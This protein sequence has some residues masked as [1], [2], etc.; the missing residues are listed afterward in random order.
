M[1]RPKVIELGEGE[2]RARIPIL[3]EDRS[4][5]AIDKPAGWMLVPF[6]WQRTQRNLPAALTSS[7][8]AGDFWATS[9]NLK[10]L[11]NVHR[12]DTDTTGVLL[13]VKSLGAVRPLSDLFRSRAMEK[14]YLAVVRGRPRK[15]EWICRDRLAKDPDQIGRM[16]VD[17][18]A[19][20]EAETRFRV[21]RAGEGS[22]VVEARP[23]TGRTHQIRVHLQRAG[24]PI[25]GDTLYAPSSEPVAIANVAFPMGLRAVRLAYRDP[26]LRKPVVIRAP[27]TDF[28]RAFG[29]NNLQLNQPHT[30]SKR[31]PS[32]PRP[33]RRP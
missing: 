22:S 17:A 8:A 32:P 1:A 3:Y 26:F 23:I 16:Q 10:L 14:T 4:V 12:L 2:D 20:Q 18:Q 5:L 29:V 15:T 31:H 11:R 24:H 25:L 7:I 33:D 30:G 28:L 27:V 21:L 19:G 13:L 9:R 6:S